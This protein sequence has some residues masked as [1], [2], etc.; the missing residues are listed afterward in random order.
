MLKKRSENA[1]EMIYRIRLK[2]E[3]EVEYISPAAAALTGCTAED[4]YFHPEI[5]PKLIMPADE[6]SARESENI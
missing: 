5:A 4:Y 1:R 3:L 2:P 6:Q